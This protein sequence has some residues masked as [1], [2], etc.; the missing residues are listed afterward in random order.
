MS[1][2]MGKWN[3][4]LTFSQVCVLMLKQQNEPLPS[5]GT[6]PHEGDWYNDAWFDL[7]VAA[8]EVHS[9]AAFCYRVEL[10]GCHFL[11]GW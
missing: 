7:V 5:P 6:E 1:D 2:G 10:V 9:K 4:D 11:I 3:N 8:G